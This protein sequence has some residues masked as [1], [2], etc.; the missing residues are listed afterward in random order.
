M[1]EN[2][3]ALSA[4]MEVPRCS[5]AAVLGRD[6]IAAALNH[7]DQNP[8]SCSSRC[9]PHPDPASTHWCF[10]TLRQLVQRNRPGIRPYHPTNSTRPKLNCYFQ[11]FQRH[12]EI[13]GIIRSATSAVRVSQPNASFPNW[14]RHQP[15]A[16]NW[17]FS[18]PVLCPERQKR[19]RSP[20]CDTIP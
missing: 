8:R 9:N 4:R 17:F 20:S 16:K 11:G 18:T 13:E 10:W 2:P 7:L 6:R 12:L 14:Y 19:E 3:L 1:L 5:A 15:L